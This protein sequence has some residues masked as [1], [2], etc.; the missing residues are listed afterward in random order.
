MHVLGEGGKTNK[1][2]KLVVVA[3]GSK[4]GDAHS[5]GQTSSRTF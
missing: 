2:F 5:L 3:E 4:I 1:K